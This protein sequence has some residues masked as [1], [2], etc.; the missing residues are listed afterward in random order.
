MQADDN[1]CKVFVIFWLAS[2]KDRDD[3]CLD[4]DDDADDGNDGVGGREYIVD[5]IRL[6]DVT[7][8]SCNWMNIMWV[9]RRSVRCSGDRPDRNSSIWNTRRCFMA[10]FLKIYLD[11]MSNA[12]FYFVI[13]NHSSS[14][15][16]I[17]K[18]AM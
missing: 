13:S 9:P 16:K 4:D 7:V 6:H 15:K 1:F 3:A 2:D 11:H 5:D 14:E 17:A 8:D 10:T 12:Q 18:L